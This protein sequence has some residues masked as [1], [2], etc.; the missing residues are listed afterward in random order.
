MVIIL[1][2]KTFKNCINF[3]SS[4][5][6]AYPRFVVQFHNADN[7]ILDPRV[8]QPTDTKIFASQMFIFKTPVQNEVRT[9][10]SKK[11]DKK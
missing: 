7:F 4:E 11:K 1:L 2:L 6:D 5:K 3:L 10:C 9:G 8:K